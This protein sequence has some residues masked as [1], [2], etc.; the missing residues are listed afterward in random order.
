MLTVN[1]CVGFFAGLKLERC[2]A[3]GIVE[4]VAGQ[5]T[6]LTCSVEGSVEWRLIGFH[7]QHLLIASCTEGVCRNALSGIL[8]ESFQVQA[9]DAQDSIITINGKNITELYDR[10]LSINSSLECF[11][12]LEKNPVGTTARCQLNF[13]RE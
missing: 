4:I 3:D 1:I 7:N 8:N 12:V 13:V 10:G 2:G 5:N 11:R 6:S 9:R